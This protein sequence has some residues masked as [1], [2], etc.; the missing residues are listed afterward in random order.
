MTKHFL[1]FSALVALMLLSAL[2]C[3]KNPNG[4]P[5]TPDIPGGVHPVP[6]EGVV[7]LGLSVLWMTRNVGAVKP[8]D[9]GSF[10]QWAGTGH[11]QTSVA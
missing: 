6:T 9:V 3:Q 8:T 1:S 10:F 7:D 11:L 2:S 4:T 5:G